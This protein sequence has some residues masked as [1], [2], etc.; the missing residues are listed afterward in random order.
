MTK[1]I[2]RLFLY[3]LT[4]IIVFT[5]S[6][7]IRTEAASVGINK[8]SITLYEGK[9]T[10]LKMVGTSKKA[11]WTSSNRKIATVDEKGKVTAVKAGRVKINVKVNGKKYT[12]KVTVKKPSLNVKDKKLTLGNSFT[13]KLVGATAKRWKTSD[14]QER[15]LLRVMPK[16]E[17]LIPAR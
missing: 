2:K 1:N 9:S 15:Q 7:P 4:L 13:L 10:K 3:L 5:M 8:T 14:K 12:C 17:L 11:T 6:F 16:M